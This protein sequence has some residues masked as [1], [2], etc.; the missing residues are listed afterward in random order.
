[1]LIALQANTQN[2]LSGK[3]TDKE[4]NEPLPGVHIYI[5]DLQKGTITNTDGFFEIRNLPQGTF[6]IKVG[7]LGYSTQVLKTTIQ[8]ETTLNIELALSIT[9]MAEIVIT[10]TSASTERKLNPIPIIVINNISFN[11]TPSTNIIDAIAKQ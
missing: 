9:E 5:P 10:G 4:T 8:G 3:T 1:M 2:N 11:E 7:Y 6:L